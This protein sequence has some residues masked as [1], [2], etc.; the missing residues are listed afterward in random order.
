[1]FFSAVASFFLL[2]ASASNCVGSP[3]DPQSLIV[4]N[5]TITHPK[6]G[7]VW[8]PGTTLNVTWGEHRDEK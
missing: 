7:M 5:P 2:A 8:V 3:I 4:F 6:A 1:M